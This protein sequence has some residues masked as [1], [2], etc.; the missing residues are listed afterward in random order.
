MLHPKSTI[1]LQPEHAVATA[2]LQQ[3]AGHR[4]WEHA[5]LTDRPATASAAADE[6]IRPVRW[7]GDDKH[8]MLT[9]AVSTL[10]GREHC[11][12]WRDRSQWCGRMRCPMELRKL[13]E[14]A[15][16]KGLLGG[17]DAAVQAFK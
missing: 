16:F 6:E 13:G 8:L 7:R 10:I 9:F 4:R 2:D 1:R 15:R 3:E 17:Y 14:V 5:N 11:K 12:E